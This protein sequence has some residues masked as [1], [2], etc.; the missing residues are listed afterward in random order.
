M[1]TLKSLTLRLRSKN[2]TITNGS[3]HIKKM[4]HCI[5]MRKESNERDM[6]QKIRNNNSKLNMKISE[7]KMKKY[8]GKC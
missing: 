6:T 3:L 7:V 4:L 2:A 5:L 8:K 1:E